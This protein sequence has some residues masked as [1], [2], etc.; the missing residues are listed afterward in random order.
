[1]CIF[2]RDIGVNSFDV[3]VRLY[4]I[5]LEISSPRVITLKQDGLISYLVLLFLSAIVLWSHLLAFFHV[6]SSIPQRISFSDLEDLCKKTPT[7]KP[8]SL[9]HQFAIPRVFIVFCIETVQRSENKRISKK[10]KLSLNLNVFVDTFSVHM[11]FLRN[12]SV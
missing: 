5:K 1:M 9:V 7:P 6:S 8:V 11:H 3:A 2:L 4:F 10:W 12:I